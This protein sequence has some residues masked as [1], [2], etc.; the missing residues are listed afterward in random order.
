MPVG[1]CVWEQGLCLCKIRKDLNGLL[2]IRFE[3]VEVPGASPDVNV[4]LRVVRAATLLTD[5]TRTVVSIMSSRSL[6]VNS[7]APS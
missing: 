7:F 1:V 3:H 6:Q 4:L 5:K 2:D